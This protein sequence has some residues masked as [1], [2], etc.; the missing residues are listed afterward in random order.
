MVLYL[1]AQLWVLGGGLRRQTG[2]KTEDPSIKSLEAAVTSLIQRNA[3]LRLDVEALKAAGRVAKYHR[4][5]RVQ[6]K[7]QRGFKSCSSL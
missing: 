4:K 1:V 2:L 3:E 7:D 6:D 5:L